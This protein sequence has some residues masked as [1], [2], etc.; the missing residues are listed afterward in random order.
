MYRKDGKPSIAKFR[1]RLTRII[2]CAETG[3]NLALRWNPK[4]RYFQPR[5][6]LVKF[7][8]E[9][10]ARANELQALLEQRAPRRN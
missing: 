1:T 7:F 9:T 3:Q 8:R 10:E 5:R 4:G 2:E 6:D